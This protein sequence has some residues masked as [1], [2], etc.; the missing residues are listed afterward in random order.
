MKRAIALARRWERLREQAEDDAEFAEVQA[1]FMEH[2]QQL[3][4]E[5]HLWTLNS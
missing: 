2:L 5:R 1:E 4:D 3:L